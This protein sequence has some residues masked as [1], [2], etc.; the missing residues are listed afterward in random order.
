MRKPV[1]SVISSAVMALMSIQSAQAGGFSLYTEGS[2]SA[3][4]NYAAGVAAEAADATTGWYNPAGLVRIKKQE[5]V[6]SGVGVLPSTK[7][8]GTS[9][10]ST[11]PIDLPYV[12]TFSGLEGAE[13]AVVPALH[14]ALPLGDRAA[15]GLSVVSPLGYQPIG[16]RTP[17][18][19]MQPLIR[20]Y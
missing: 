4:G 17:P 6:L 1:Q 12:Q 3:V 2:A 14:Y 16:T 13:N 5:G 9:T 20:N 15:F 7:L 19:D 8:T 11:I 10:Y 18:F